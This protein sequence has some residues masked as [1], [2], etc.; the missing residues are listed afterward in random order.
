MQSLLSGCGSI[1]LLGEANFSFSLSLRKMLPSDISMVTTCFQTGDVIKS[2]GDGDIQ[3]NIANLQSLGACVV[4]GIDATKLDQYTSLEGAPYDA[5]IFNFPHVGGKGNIGRNRDLLKRFFECCSQR[6]SPSGQVFLTLCNG[7]GGTP[8]DQPQRIWGNSWQVVAMAA[9]GAFI[10]TR[11]MPFCAKDYEDYDCTGY[12][13]QS[14]GFLTQSSITHIFERSEEHIHTQPC[15]TPTEL[16]I[17]T[18]QGVVTLDCPVD[19][20]RVIDRDI[21]SEAHHPVSL[22]SRDLHGQ[23]DESFKDIKYCQ[24]KELPLVLDLEDAITTGHCSPSELYHLKRTPHILQHNGSHGNQSSG[25]PQGAVLG[26]VASHQQP[27][28]SSSDGNSVVS[29]SCTYVPRIAVDSEKDGELVVEDDSDSDSSN[30]ETLKQDSVV[31]SEENSRTGNTRTVHSNSHHSVSNGPHNTP[32][33]KVPRYQSASG[34]TKKHFI[35]RPTLLTHV[36]CSLGD[37]VSQGVYICGRV[38][39]RCGIL[40]NLYP[41]LHQSLIVVRTDQGDSGKLSK[42]FKDKVLRVSANLLRD[43]GSV[44]INECLGDQDGSTSKHGSLL[45]KVEGSNE[46]SDSAFTI[47]QCGIFQ[48]GGWSYSYCTFNIDTIAMVKYNVKDIRLFW[49]ADDRIFTKFS[50]SVER[51][52]ESDPISSPSLEGY[53]LHPPAYTHDI[54]FWLNDA[55]YDEFHFYSLI[56]AV[57]CDLVRE[58]HFLHKYVNQKISYNYRLVYQSCDRALTR[59][60]ATQLQLDVRKALDECPG[61]GVNPK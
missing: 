5:I 3:K 7:Q 39:R 47:G 14:K 59:Q 16:A 21:L 55:T 52:S 48:S 46:A 1:L 56:R 4:F 29:V 36:P 57:T 58:V 8:A 41:I 61:L 27:S 37:T 30:K 20:H 43:K 13:S 44:S 42:S 17:Q 19:L 33:A 49:S 10:L 35:L 50:E 31:S 2:S 32:L 54:S 25:V 34:H 18:D 9:Y 40:P 53:S 51:C 6:L 12:R 26:T 23:I 15:Q 45:F 38:F 60:E 28:S 11:T 24:D 22:V